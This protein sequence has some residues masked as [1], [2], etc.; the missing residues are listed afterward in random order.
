MVCCVIPA[1]FFHERGKQISLLRPRYVNKAR[2][3]WKQIE[4]QL[5]SEFEGHEFNVK[6]GEAREKLYSKWGP[7]T[8]QSTENERLAS[9]KGKYKGERVFII[10]NGP[11]LNKTPLDKLDGEFTFA[12]NRFYL[13]YDQLS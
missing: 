13:M 7:I 4:Q 5:N 8:C 3:S 12:M 6:W 2:K 10:G 1:N 11:S 9:L